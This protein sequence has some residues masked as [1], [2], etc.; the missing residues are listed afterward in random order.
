MSAT[1]K[2]AANVASS[3]ES[4]GPVTDMPLTALLQD[5]SS[6]TNLVLCNL[7]VQQLLENYALAST[8]TN[9][10]MSAHDLWVLLLAIEFRGAHVIDPRLFY[11]LATM[12]NIR[13]A[14]A[15]LIAE[16]FNRTEAQHSEGRIH[17]PIVWTEEASFASFTPLDSDAVEMQRINASQVQRQ[18][19][20][21]CAMLASTLLLHG[22]QPDSPLSKLQLPATVE[23]AV[24]QYWNAPAASNDGTRWPTLSVAHFVSADLDPQMEE[25]REFVVS[26]ILDAHAEA[27]DP[28]PVNGEF[29]RGTTSDLHL[30]H[31]PIYLVHTLAVHPR[32]LSLCV[33]LQ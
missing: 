19:Q 11:K 33:T 10:A 17:L 20:R 7:P 26:G 13:P 29:E 8:G 16:A 3:V 5:E 2:S 4:Q 24:G 23:D 15:P 21:H 31:I 22:T 25:L 6:I 30:D 18:L 9:R 1:T 27:T 14:D 32:S 28:V 12:H